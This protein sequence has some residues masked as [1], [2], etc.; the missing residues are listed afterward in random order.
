ML[1]ALVATA[2]FAQAPEAVNPFDEADESAMF[3]MDEELVTVASRYAQTLRKA[4]SIVALVTA[5]QIRT[6][7]YRTL[8]DVLRQLPGF[9]LWKSPEG[10]DLAAVRGIVSSDNNRLLVLVDGVPWYDGVYT[11][12]S[13]DDYLPLGQVKQIEVIKGPGSAI[14]GTNAFAGV[15]NVVTWSARDLEGGELRATAGARGRFEGSGIVGGTYQVGD[16][17]VELVAFARVLDS[18]GDGPDVTPR[19]R[20]NV[21]A[22][23]PVH[24]VTAGGHFRVG[25]LSVQLHSVD[26]LR[27]YTEN[28]ADSPMSIANKD[29]SEYRIAN[30]DLFLDVRADIPLSDDVGVT[31][32]FWSQH[33]NNPGSYSYSK[34][35]V[36]ERLPSSDFGFGT[37]RT[38]E[39]TVVV[40]AA[41]DTRRMGAGV[42]VHARPAL[43][44]QLVGGAGVETVRVLE[45]SD[46]DYS[47]DPDVR[48]SQ[49]LAQPTGFEAPAG[50]SLWNTY[51]YAQWT[52]TMLPQLELTSGGRVDLRLAPVG[53]EDTSTSN[54]FAP[55][56]SPRA[57]LLWVPTEQVT[58]KLLYGSAFRA[59]TVRE[60]LVVA[61]IGDDGLHTFAS[62]NLDV[63]P[64]TIQTVEAQLAV[65]PN[66]W[67]KTSVSTSYSAFNHEIDKVAPPRAYQNLIPTLKI[68]GAE[69]AVGVRVDRLDADVS[70]A[71]TDARYAG[72]PDPAAPAT[73]YAG[74]RQYEFPPHMVKA[75]LGFQPVPQVTFWSG[76]EG[77]STRPRQDWAGDVNQDDGEAFALVHAGVRATEIGREHKLRAGLAVRNVLNSEWST[78][79]YRDD[80]GVGDAATGVPKFPNGFEG[81]GRSFLATLE[82]PI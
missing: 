72:E 7:G 56:V 76:I 68:L 47:P 40:D 59:P 64:E 17:Q 26:Y 78:G 62:G 30:H 24:A 67:L 69:A 37:W 82:I 34:G 8:S 23:D 77:Y 35:F 80:I 73:I 19:G 31:P 65:V 12:A 70:Y 14:Y 44:H 71:F 54:A 52:W 60:L 9:Y 11:H 2:A 32:F 39:R 25:V 29:I 66:D 20:D 38:Y 74:R 58:A 4:P 36:T 21:L 48:N 79:V 45:L 50:A 42:D 6:R 28:E 51:V 57:G 55:V 18:I 27:S 61:P 43:D 15:V 13:I 63:S 41:K 22:T 16:R 1:L 53:V 33:H 3:R 75:N 10:R 46:R 81:E 49:H 5:D